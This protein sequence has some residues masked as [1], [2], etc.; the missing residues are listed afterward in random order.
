MYFLDARSESVGESYSRVTLDRI[1]IPA[2]IPHYEVWNHGVLVDRADF[3]WQEF[4]TPR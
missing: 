3:C 1:G 2:P 4:R